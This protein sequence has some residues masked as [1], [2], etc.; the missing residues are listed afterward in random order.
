MLCRTIKTL[1]LHLQLL[2]YGE[3][4]SFY[5]QHKFRYDRLNS[6]CY[7]HVS[8]KMWQVTELMQNQ[9]YELCLLIPHA[10]LVV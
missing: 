6:V 10:M 2:I 8:T 5:L 7:L 3:I 1:S 4:G 9:P